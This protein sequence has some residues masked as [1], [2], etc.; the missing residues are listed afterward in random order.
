MKNLLRD[1]LLNAVLRLK[2]YKS[3]LPVNLDIPIGEFVILQNIELIKG[4][5][6][7][8][9]YVSDI[10]KTIPVSKSAVSQA[11]GMLEKKNYILREIAKDDHRKIEVILTPQGKDILLKNKVVFEDIFDELI[12]RMGEENVTQLVIYINKFAAIM[13]DMMKEKNQQTNHEHMNLIE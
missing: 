7:G 1:Q 2:K 9:V 3:P 6:N 13:E 4:Q 11:L 12:S 8:K 10:M 5:N